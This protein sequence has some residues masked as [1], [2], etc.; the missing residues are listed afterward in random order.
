MSKEEIDK[1]YSYIPFELKGYFD[2]TK[3]TLV[4]TPKDGENGYEIITPFYCY[5]DEN[6]KEQAVLVD[7]GWI[8][9]QWSEHKKHLEGA[10]GPQT[11]T[12][13]VYK[14][15]SSNKYSRSNEGKHDK[16]STIKPQEFATKLLLDNRDIAGQFMFKQVDLDNKSNPF[17]KTLNLDDLE[18]WP[19]DAR[20][21]LNYSSMWYALTYANIFG[22]LF[23]WL[24]L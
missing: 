8:T 19:V 5:T 20:T 15:D 17:P 3:E 22:N 11:I 13:I 14:G 18:N 23:F 1:E 2:H 21:N 24:Y 7:R 6:G 12:G 10:V 16:W 9:E 4:H